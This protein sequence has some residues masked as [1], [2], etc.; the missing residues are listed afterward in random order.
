[1]LEYKLLSVSVGKVALI[2]G[3]TSGIGR[4]AAIGFARRGDFV[5][6]TGRR[7]DEGKKTLAL[8]REAGSDGIFV[9]GDVSRAARAEEMVARAVE[10]FG[11]L[12]Y[13]FNNAGVEGHYAPIHEQTEE[14]YEF[15]MDI[16]VRG[17]LLSM[18]Y[19]I[20]QMRRNGGGVIVNNSS[21]AGLC[22]FENAG[23]YAASKFAVIGLTKVGAVENATHGIRVNAICPGGVATEMVDRMTG[24]SEKVEKAFA[25]A[26]PMNRLGRPEEIADIVLWLC[27]DQSTFLTGQALG[28]DGGVSASF[29]GKFAFD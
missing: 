27:S 28:I 1:M 14:N 2:T 5:V 12:D 10:A 15:V 26:H 16:N 3:G 8:V 23:V 9:P 22:G 4:A 20:A 19:E 11:R 25:A 6:L 18:K 13:A 7:E 21:V 24:K 29:G 17:V